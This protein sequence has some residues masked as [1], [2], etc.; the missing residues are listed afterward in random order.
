MDQ[1]SLTKF[2]EKEIVLVSK[3]C[4]LLSHD[5]LKAFKK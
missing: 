1:P 4:F 2:V 5:Q 3:L